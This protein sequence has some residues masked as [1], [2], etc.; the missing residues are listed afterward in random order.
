MDPSVESELRLRTELSS[1]L[2]LIQLVL[3]ASHTTLPAARWYVNKVV[4]AF[5]RGLKYKVSG[6]LEDDLALANYF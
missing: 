6:H 2:Q 5:A 1:L 4:E 3:R